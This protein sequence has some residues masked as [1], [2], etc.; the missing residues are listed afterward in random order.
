MLIR[1]LV[2]SKLMIDLTKLLGLEGFWKCEHNLFLYPNPDPDKSTSSMKI[3]SLLFN[4]FVQMEYTWVN[5]G[6][7]QA[8]MLVIGY[9]HSKKYTFSCN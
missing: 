7:D 3:R 9:D 8:G 4:K 6:K 1:K 2:K 5:S